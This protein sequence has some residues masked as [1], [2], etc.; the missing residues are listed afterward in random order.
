MYFPFSRSE[1]Y[2]GFKHRNHS[3]SYLCLCSANEPLTRAGVDG[4]DR[5]CPKL[6]MEII[7]RFQANWRLRI[8][9]LK[10]GTTLQ[11]FLRISFLEKGARSVTIIIVFE[12]NV[13]LTSIFH[14][15]LRYRY[16]S[17]VTLNEFFFLESGNYCKRY[18]KFIPKTDLFVRRYYCFRIKFK[19]NI[20]SLSYFKLSKRISYHYLEHTSENGS[21]NVFRVQYFIIDV[22]P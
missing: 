16:T 8:S 15:I 14:Y 10:A 12:R 2:P 18:I 3:H 17:A 11:S 1:F 5:G 9:F 19:R 22:T 7:T 21:G 6:E 20:D 4:S 13:N